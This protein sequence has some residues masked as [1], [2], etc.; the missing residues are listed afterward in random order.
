MKEES[1]WEF[2]DF[3]DRLLNLHLLSSI[4]NALNLTLF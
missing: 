3:H 4:N 1:N 2:I